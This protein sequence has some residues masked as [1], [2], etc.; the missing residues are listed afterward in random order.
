[1]LPQ[2]DCDQICAILT[3]IPSFAKR[4][5]WSKANFEY[6]GSGSARSV[7]SLD[8][9]TVIKVA[10]NPF[11]LSQNSVEGDYGLSH[12]YGDLLA[13]VKYAD[14]ENYTFIISEKAHVI[15]KSPTGLKKILLAEGIDFDE[16]EKITDHLDHVIRNMRLDRDAYHE[17]DLLATKYSENDIVSKVIDMCQSFSLLPGDFVRHSSWGSVVCQDGSTKICIKDYGLNVTNQREFIAKRFQE[18]KPKLRMGW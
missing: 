18:K 5:A 9:D 11:G 13:R 7:F 10:K 6:I 14:D 1:M 17:F 15:A 2:R 4:I 3:S 8:E 16:F 12:M